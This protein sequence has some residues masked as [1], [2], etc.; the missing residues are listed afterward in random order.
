M[1][2]LILLF[3]IPI[4]IY[5]N[6]KLEKLIQ[7]SE[8][9]WSKIPPKDKGMDFLKYDSYFQNQTD[10][11]IKKYFGEKMIP[12]ISYARASNDWKES[13]MNQIKQV[14]SIGKGFSMSF[15]DIH[16]GMYNTLDHLGKVVLI[17]FFATFCYPCRRNTTKLTALKDKYGDKISVVIISSDRT[18]ESIYNYVQ[19]L[20]YKFPTNYSNVGKKLA[21][22]IGA[23]LG[24]IYII[25]KEGNLYDIH[26]HHNLEKKVAKII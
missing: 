2:N 26:G 6:T 25:N 4:M 19:K 13:R 17:D 11:E 9:R 24:T 18:K 5:G 15:Q 10:P 23:S 3:L 14:N 12:T 8:E 16:G 21:K 20:K 7:E 22:D 1:K